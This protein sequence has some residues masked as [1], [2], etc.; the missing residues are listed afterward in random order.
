MGP[1]GYSAPRPCHEK[2]LENMH[3]IFF[4]NHQLLPDITQIYLRQGSAWASAC[5]A[6]LHHA[7]K[8]SA[9]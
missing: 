3:W 5:L 8:S 1:E 4:P 7:L 2:Q 6:Y 9:Q